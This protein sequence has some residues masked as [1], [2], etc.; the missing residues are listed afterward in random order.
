MN[1]KRVPFLLM[2]KGRVT[3]AGPLPTFTGFP[4]KPMRAPNFLYPKAGAIVKK[5]NIEMNPKFL[6]QGPQLI[7]PHFWIAILHFRP[8][9]KP[10]HD[11]SGV[12]NIR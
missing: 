9:L 6:Q 8:L 5:K 7:P 10:V 11:L 12:V 3:A 1:A 4:I 2:K